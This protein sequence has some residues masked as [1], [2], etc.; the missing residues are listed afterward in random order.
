MRENNGTICG[1]VVLASEVHYE[2][3]CTRKCRKKLNKNGVKSPS[4]EYFNYF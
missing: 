4:S 2:K 1:I 3:I